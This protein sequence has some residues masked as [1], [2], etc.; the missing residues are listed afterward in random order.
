MSNNEFSENPSI[1][2]EFNPTFP[3]WHW[4]IKTQCEGIA[5][6]LQYFPTRTQ[7]Y[8]DALEVLERDRQQK[9]AWDIMKNAF[10]AARLMGVN[11]YN[12]LQGLGWLCFHTPELRKATGHIERAAYTVAGWNALTPA[13]MAEI[14]CRVIDEEKHE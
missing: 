13:D 2:I 3:G 14:I 4:I 6:D 7:A 5:K 1:R 9:I 12:F 11:D 8:L 10:S